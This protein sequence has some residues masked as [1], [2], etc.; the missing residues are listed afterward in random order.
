VNTV[1]QTAYCKRLG[2][3]LPSYLKVNLRLRQTP[4]IVVSGVL[5]ISGDQRSYQD[6]YGIMSSRKHRGVSGVGRYSGNQV[7]QRRG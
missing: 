3:T 1:A 2:P 7:D 6:Q 5:V 4:N